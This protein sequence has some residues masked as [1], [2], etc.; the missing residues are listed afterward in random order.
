MK[1]N[2]SII[3]MVLA[4]ILLLGCADWNIKAQNPTQ[5][6]TAAAT[7]TPIT[8]EEDEI[9]LIA[10]ATPEPTE[11]PTPEPTDTPTPSPVPTD[12]PTPEPE[13]IIGWSTG[14][15]VSREEMSCTEEEYVSD[16]LH[17]TVTKYEDAETYAR[18]V[19]YFVTDLYIRD[20][21]CLKTYAAAEF[22]TKDTK[23]FTYVHKIAKKANALWAMTG[24]YCGHHKHSL[25]IRN[26]TVYDLKLYSDWDLLFLYNDGVMETMAAEDF[27]AD[28][29]RNDVWQA[30]QFGPSLL[31]ADGHAIEK[32]QKYSKIST[33]NPRSVIGYIEPGHYIFVTVDGR[34]GR[35][36]G[37]LTLPETAQ[38]MES[39]GCK[40]AYNLDGGESA[41]LYWTGQTYNSPS[42]NGRVISD[43][44]YLIDEDGTES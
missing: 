20:L 14:G 36:S 25:I 17:F 18:R 4:A 7:E 40:L 15:F 34:Q 10:T 22:T 2:I 1:R 31:D 44:I 12:T 41:Q 5:E 3:C 32:F 21:S 6:P 19:T 37:G 24:D 9:R 13:G 27:N 43:I 16:K 30:W 11:V 35:Y 33:W 23:K 29:L 42:D 8:V 26:G 28:T 38:L 39:L